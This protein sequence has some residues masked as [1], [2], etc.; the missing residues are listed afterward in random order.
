MTHSKRLIYSCSG[1]SNVAQLA[2]QIA[3]EFSKEHIAEMSCIAGVGGN[4]KHLVLQAKKAES[5]IALDGC[6]LHCVKHCLANHN[7]T[8]K[9]HFTLSDYDIKKQKHSDYLVDDVKRI[10]ALLLDEL[11]HPLNKEP[12]SRHG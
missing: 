3:I 5:I 8:A 10:K 9:Y 7:L 6:P 12:L 1:C 4:V 11:N 2:N